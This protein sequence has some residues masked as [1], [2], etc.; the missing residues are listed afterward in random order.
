MA[1]LENPGPLTKHL[2]YVE[3][4]DRKISF[5]KTTKWWWIFVIGGAVLWGILWIVIRHVIF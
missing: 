3:I 4:K 5:K 1:D 2:G